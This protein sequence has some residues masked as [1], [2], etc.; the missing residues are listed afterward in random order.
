MKCEEF[1]S[2]TSIP[3]KNYNMVQPAMIVLNKSGEVKNV[4][5]WNT[6]ELKKVEPQ[7][8]MTKVEKYEGIL[9]GIRPISSDIPKSIK[10]NRDVKLQFQGMDKIKLEMNGPPPPEKI[11]IP[12]VVGVIVI[13]TM[14]IFRK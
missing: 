1:E 9:V 2:K 7:N 12:V 4:W 6:G 3:Y 5:S 11:S 14:L 10:E 8:A 13:A